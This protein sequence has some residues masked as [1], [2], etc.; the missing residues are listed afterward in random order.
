MEGA[1]S[2]PVLS[3][4]GD[5]DLCASQAISLPSAVVQQDVRGRLADMR[6]GA[7]TS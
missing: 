3:S 2:T 5:V 4:V 6:K 1:V 7:V